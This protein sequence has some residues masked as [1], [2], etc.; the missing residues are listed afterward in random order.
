[1][2]MPAEVIVE[3]IQ[4]TIGRRVSTLAARGS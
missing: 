4:K 1:M 2:T 3:E